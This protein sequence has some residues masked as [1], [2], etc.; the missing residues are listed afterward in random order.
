MNQNHS[1]KTAVIVCSGMMEDYGYYQRYLQTADMIIC[2]DGGGIHMKGLGVMPHVLMGDFDS[3]TPENLDELRREGTRIVQFPREKDFTD[4]ELTV[5]YAMEQGAEV[6]ILLGALGVRMDHGISNVF[7][8]KRM[9][10]RG[11]EGLIVD[12]H[13]EIRMTKDTM[14]LLNNGGEM[15]SLIPVTPVVRGV[16]TEG[17]YYPLRDA[18]LTMDSTLGV[19]NRFT[20]DAAQVSLEEGILLVI[21]S[22]D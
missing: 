10:D 19:S 3:I 8:L 12:E 18:V 9:M 17:L 14:K 4:S 5:E 20:G 16:T 6:I 7:L 13:N 22:R 2:A 1:K 15:V 21:K 11:V